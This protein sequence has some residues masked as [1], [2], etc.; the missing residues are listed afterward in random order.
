METRYKEHSFYLLLIGLKSVILIND[1]GNLPPVGLQGLSR[2][3]MASQFNAGAR[4]LDQLSSI[5]SW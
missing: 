4:C 5:K 1:L 3:T 2:P